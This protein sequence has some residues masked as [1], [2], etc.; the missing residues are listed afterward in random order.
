MD[1]LGAIQSEAWRGEIHQGNPEVL[2]KVNWPQ[3]QQLVC[4]LKLA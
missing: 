2:D 4:F 1:F 3:I